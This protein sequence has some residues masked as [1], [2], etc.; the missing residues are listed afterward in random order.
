MTPGEGAGVMY[1]SRHS[2]DEKTSI[3]SAEDVWI[4]L[5]ANLSAL[6]MTG[7]CE[8]NKLTTFGGCTG[9]MVLAK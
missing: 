2:F 6:L 8:T 3:Q 9:A 4:G 1:D 7:T 5:V